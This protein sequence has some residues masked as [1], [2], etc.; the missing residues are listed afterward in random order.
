MNINVTKTNLNTIIFVGLIK[1]RELLRNSTF[2]D[3][4]DAPST[5][6]KHKGVTSDCYIVYCMIG[7]NA[8]EKTTDDAIQEYRHD[9]F[10]HVVLGIRH[11]PSCETLRQRIEALP[12]GNTDT[13]CAGGTTRS[14]PAD[15]PT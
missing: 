13:S 9:S 3:E 6:L 2:G 11:V 10:F 14:S 1:I 5:E 7:L 15:S 12:H 8:N 4:I